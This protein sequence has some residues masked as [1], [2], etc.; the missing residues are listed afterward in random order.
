MPA[1]GIFE[2]NTVAFQNKLISAENNISAKIQF[3]N[4][5]G[6][7]L[8]DIILRPSAPYTLLESDSRLLNI[9]IEQYGKI[10]DKYQLLNYHEKKWHEH[11][12]LPM[13]KEYLHNLAEKGNGEFIL[14]DKNGIG[15]ALKSISLREPVVVSEQKE[16]LSPLYGNKIVLLLFLYL[17]ISSFYLKSRYAG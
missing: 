3:M 1:V 11:S 9:T 12:Y 16:T 8:K 15:A 7:I 6:R 4:Y 14:A 13:G 10:I 2:N 5:D 17:V